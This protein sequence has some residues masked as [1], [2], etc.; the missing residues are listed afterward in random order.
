MAGGVR[1]RGDGGRESGGVGEGVAFESVGG[2]E[3]GGGKEEEG[4]LGTV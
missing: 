2:G 3:G 4:V 1:F